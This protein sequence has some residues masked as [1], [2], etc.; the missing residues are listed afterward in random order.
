MAAPHARPPQGASPEVRE[1][2]QALEAFHAAAAAAD[3]A[4]LLA[5]FDAEGTFLGTDGSERWQGEA[6]HAFVRERM[7][8]GRGW[9]MRARRR[10]LAAG[11]GLAWFDEDLDHE[12]LGR[13][14]GSGVLRRGSDGAWRVLLYDL[15]AP[16]PNERLA[17]VRALLAGPAAGPAAGATADP[18]AR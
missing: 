10:A 16:I 12:G 9:V 17:A 11:G 5:R 13:L 1:A 3:S 8:G 6:F 7:A 4:A 2:W 15:S 14:R 18:A